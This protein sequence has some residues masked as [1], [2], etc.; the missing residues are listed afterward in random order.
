MYVVLSQ[1]RLK[2]ECFGPPSRNS[3]ATVSREMFVLRALLKLTQLEE[4]SSHT[5]KGNSYEESGQSARHANR[6]NAPC[7]STQFSSRFPVNHDRYCFLISTV[8]TP[9]S[10]SISTTKDS[11][12]VKA[13]KRGHN[14][15]GFSSDVAGINDDEFQGSRTIAAS[16]NG[17]MPLL[18][19]LLLYEQLDPRC[20][21]NLHSLL[22]RIIVVASDSTTVSLMK[23]SGDFFYVF[24]FCLSCSGNLK[25]SNELV[26]M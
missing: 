20:R 5:T 6:Y 24:S 21:M 25:T 13:A 23:K 2:C 8:A 17:K 12:P 16:P 22:R 14:R 4:Q 11:T 9:L 15:K 26:N 18:L 7:E 10:S 1:S 3:L 19:L